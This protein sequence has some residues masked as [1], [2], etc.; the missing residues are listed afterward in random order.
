M[1]ASNEDGTRTGIAILL[2]LTG[3]AFADT[4]RVHYS[5]RGK[6]PL[7]VTVR[8]ESS[9]QARRTV[10]EMFPGATVTGVHR[11]KLR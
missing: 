3:R 4:F 7:D 10:M 6:R 8:A 2:F 1:G 5:V 11:V 9:S